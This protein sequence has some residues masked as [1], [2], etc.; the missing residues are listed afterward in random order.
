LG[1][2][3]VVHKSTCAQW[4]PPPKLSGR[5]S[6]SV[7][8][9]CM[10]ES[11]ARI[12]EFK[13]LVL[14]SGVDRK[15]IPA[16]VGEPIRTVGSWLGG[17]GTPTAQAI[18]K[19]T[20]FVAK[21]SPKPAKAKASKTPK[22]TKVVAVA[23]KAPSTKGAKS[24]PVEPPEVRERKA[25]KRTFERVLSE[26]GI[27]QAEAASILGISAGAVSKLLNADDRGPSD[28]QIE[29]M[30]AYVK[31]R[32]Q[33]IENETSALMAAALV[34]LRAEVRKEARRKVEAEAREAARQE[35]AEL[36]EQEAESSFIEVRDRMIAEMRK[37]PAV[38]AKAEARSQSGLQRRAE[39]EAMRIVREQVEQ[40]LLADL[41]GKEAARRRKKSAELV[42]AIN[43]YL[44]LAHMQALRPGELGL[45][46][47]MIAAMRRIREAAH[48]GETSEAR[49]S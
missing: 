26:S 9:G 18:E 39:L 7:E 15:Q 1:C 28:D 13:N 24:A 44:D 6:R 40:S 30:R 20:A 37:D 29:I 46:D 8:E 45:L 23:R 14:R 34:R 17:K 33:V 3:A 38:R 10:D 21:D 22:G 43:E 5:K 32:G 48:Y 35:L 4:V 42:Q 12:S 31:V 49:A 16:I 11:K 27:N 47:R 41:I 25:R 36:F 2:R 19:L